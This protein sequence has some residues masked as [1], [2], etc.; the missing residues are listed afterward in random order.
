MTREEMQARGLIVL[1]VGIY[2]P[3][4]ELFYEPEFFGPGR[5]EAAEKLFCMLRNSADA[6]GLRVR[7]L[8][9]NGALAAFVPTPQTTVG[10]GGL[11]VAGGMLCQIVD[12]MHDEPGPPAG[13]DE[14][15]DDAKLLQ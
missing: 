2:S 15:D 1:V 5:A 4:R 8:A 11:P 7:M 12:I 13:P 14:D 10:A 9:I 3:E 6:E